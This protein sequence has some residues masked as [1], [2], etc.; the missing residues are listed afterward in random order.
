[1]KNEGLIEEF[2]VSIITGITD[3]NIT[4]SNSNQNKKN[5]IL[6]YS[7]KIGLATNINMSIS[8]IISIFQSKVNDN[9]E[10]KLLGLNTAISKVVLMSEVIKSRLKGIHQVLSI[11]CYDY[12]KDDKDQINDKK[13]KKKS[14]ISND[15]EKLTPKIEITL[16]NF[17]PL[18]KTEGYQKP[19][20]IYQLYKLN[21][22]S[23]SQQI[24]KTNKIDTC[25]Y[26]KEELN[27]KVKIKNT[28]TNNII[29]KIKTSVV[30][31]KEKHY[32]SLLNQRINNRLIKLLNKVNLQN[33]SNN[34]NISS[35]LTQKSNSRIKYKDR[36]LKSLIRISLIKKHYL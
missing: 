2:D 30:K 26:D 4:T 24:S 22:C 5:F 17:E 18:N 19:Y 15:V 35:L 8:N 16:S 25:D 29:S 13:S 34:K 33:N 32:L 20:S 31:E 21:T 7:F 1:M 12:N 36:L 27:S 28:N 23:G 6:S 14:N 11:G 10:I 3:P 9:I